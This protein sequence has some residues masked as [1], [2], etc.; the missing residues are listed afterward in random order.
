MLQAD[1][2][3]I[4]VERIEELEEKSL[5]DDITIEG[6]KKKI[7]ELEKENAICHKIIEAYDNYTDG[8]YDFDEK[9]ELIY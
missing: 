2:N 4:Y 5:Q 7:Q 3:D 9:G 6:L 1:P 8:Q